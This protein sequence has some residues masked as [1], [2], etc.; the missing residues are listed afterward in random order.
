MDI[1]QLIWKGFDE[2][3]FDNLN[4]CLTCDAILLNW[5]WSLLAAFRSI[6]TCSEPTQTSFTIEDCKKQLQ[7]LHSWRFD[8]SCHGL[9]GKSCFDF[10]GRQLV[11]KKKMD[12]PRRFY[13]VE[14]A[15]KETTWRCQ[16]SAQWNVKLCL[17]GF[18]S[19]SHK[20]KEIAWICIENRD[21]I[22]LR[23]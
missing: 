23:Q 1:V 22:Q 18:S 20:L 4:F 12:H 19:R 14:H 3:E 17:S 11:A 5:C 16:W 21:K 15:T 13:N 6:R 7:D 10:Q 2:R 8:C 9:S